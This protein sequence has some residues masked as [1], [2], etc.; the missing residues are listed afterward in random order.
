[1]PRLLTAILAALLLTACATTPAPP[2]P[3]AAPADR[4]CT[5]SDPEPAPAEETLRLT[6]ATYNVLG[7]PPPPEWYP[8]IEPAELDPTARQPATVAKINH[9]DADVI[10]LQEYRPELESGARLAA[11]LS[12]YTWVAPSDPAAGPEAVAVPI[13][14]RTDRF[15][16]LA[17]GNEKVTTVGENGSMLDRHVN[18]VELRDRTSGR[19][20]FVFNYHAHPWQ[21]AEFAALRSSAVDRLIDLVERVN[22]GFA[23]PFAITGDFNA[24]NNDTRR[25]YGDHLRAFGKAGIV[26]SAAIAAKD[27]SDVPRAASMNKMSAKVAGEYIGKVVRRNGQHID[28]VWVPEGTTVRSWA[29]VSGPGLAWRKVRGKKVPVWTGIVASDHSPV[30]ADLKFG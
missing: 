25:V 20:F 1:M 26:D 19:R 17:T 5:P 24:R 13:L 21:T 12:Q 23:E 4:I 15:D 7:G 6:V 22:P 10:G 3:P 8:Q 14:F 29:T 2:L 28:Y 16:C 18:W 27:T 9:L 30:V 11:D